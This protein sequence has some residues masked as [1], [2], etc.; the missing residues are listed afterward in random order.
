MSLSSSEA[1]RGRVAVITGAGSGIGR[2]TAL[3][4][5]AEGAHVVVN[6]VDEARAAETAGLVTATGGSAVAVAGDVSDAAHV[7]ELVAE[8]V[9]RH[10]RLDVMHNNAGYGVPSRVADMT[11]DELDLM[12]R[13]HVH[14][15]M[16][17]TR[18]ALAVMIE[19]GGGSIINTASNAALGHA[20]GRAS[21]SA[22]KAAVV[23]LTRSTAVEN[24]QF[25]VRANAICPGPIR[26]PAFERFAPDL[27]YYAAQIPMRRL[28]DAED[29]AALAL[30]L[31]S[32]ESRY[33][34][35]TAIPIDGGLRARLTAPHLTPDD[36]TA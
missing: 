32:D 1:L 23:S 19:Q 5:A 21:Y 15:T 28:G 10:G 22:A 9:R 18:A 4:F 25:G 20:T 34:T 7:D 17:G 16:H 14:G 12:L 11:D 29:V 36:V 30:F 8:A 26:T 2:A 24:G 35:G 6:D 33:V 3:R 13:V 27:D 31:A